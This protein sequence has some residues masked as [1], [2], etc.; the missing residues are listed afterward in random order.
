MQSPI[1]LACIID[2]D[3]MYTNL[4]IKMINKKKLSK[5]LLTFKNGKEAL[6]YFVQTLEKTAEN[7]APQIILLDLNMPVMDGWQFLNELEQHNFPQLKN[8]T[9]YI[10]SSSINPADMERSKTINL[11]NDF[12]VKPVSSE[13]LSQAL[14]KK[15]A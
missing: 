4:I 9:L 8:T 13:E 6:D 12:L 15:T 2:D 3:D 7:K 14:L 10:V 5:D 1:E 11:V